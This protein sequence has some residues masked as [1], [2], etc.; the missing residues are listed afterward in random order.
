MAFK[1]R[2]EYI[3]GEFR[4]RDKGKSK[5]TNPHKL[6]AAWAEKEIRNLKRIS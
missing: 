3:S 1:D 6:I 5:R 4:F 2:E